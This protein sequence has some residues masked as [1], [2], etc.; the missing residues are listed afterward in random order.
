M[1]NTMNTKVS[2]DLHLDKDYKG[3]PGHTI[4][5]WRLIK[6]THQPKFNRETGYGRHHSTDGKDF[7]AGSTSAR[8][9]DRLIT[10]KSNQDF[11]INAKSVELMAI[12]EIPLATPE[13][14]KREEQVAI[15][16][17]QAF[18]EPNEGATC[19]NVNRAHKSEHR[20]DKKL[21]NKLVKTLNKGTRD[22][23]KKER[24]YLEDG[25]D[26][27]KRLQDSIAKTLR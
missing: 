22:K 4:Y 15:N 14:I 25:R 11:V 24:G 18:C 3:G 9:Q 6:K 19:L 7:Y 27:I 23:I 12:K 21:F 1:K 17:V 8:I 20:I 26:I 16:T 10:P 5:I 13:D 2:G